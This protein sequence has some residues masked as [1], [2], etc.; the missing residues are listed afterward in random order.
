MK[1]IDLLNKKANGEEMPKKIYFK[2]HYYFYDDGDYHCEN[3]TWLF[4]GNSM[5]YFLNDE[6]EIIEEKK[7]IPEKIKIEGKSI[8]VK[9]TTFFREK[10]IGIFQKLSMEINEILDYLESKG[11]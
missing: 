7:K 4:H 10:D 9:G 11:E 2:T 8:T 6:I 1:I 3:G 5:I